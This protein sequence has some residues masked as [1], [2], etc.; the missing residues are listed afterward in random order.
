MR[1]MRDCSLDLMRTGESERETWRDERSEATARGDETS[2][3]TT[4]TNKANAN[5]EENR[6]GF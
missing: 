2:K 5:G 6:L 3:R 4:A 1:P